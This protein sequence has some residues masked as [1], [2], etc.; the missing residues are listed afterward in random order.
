ML[1]R[2]MDRTVCVATQGRVAMS[3]RAE[4]SPKPKTSRFS[5]WLPAGL[6]VAALCAVGVYFAQNPAAFE[7]ARK[8]L[9]FGP[10][11][12]QQAPEEEVPSTAQATKPDPVESMEIPASLA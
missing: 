5:D 12:A 3:R 1:P 7:Q 4:T 10:E 11:A 9:G 2:L 6:L 8:T